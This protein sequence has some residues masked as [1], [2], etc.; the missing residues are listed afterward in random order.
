MRPNLAEMTG[1]DE[2]WSIAGAT[3][4][5]GISTATDPVLKKFCTEKAIRAFENA[6]SI[7]PANIAHKVNLAL[8]YA[9]NPPPEE[10]MKG[11]LLLLELDK[12]NPGEPAVLLA[13]ARLALKTGQYDKALARL[14]SVLK[15]EPENNR[16]ICLLP[17][18]YNGLGNTAEAETV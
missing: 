5:G 8:C 18:A 17:E 9:E 7:N 10:P 6:Y 12:Q 3:F 16:A 1:S 2:R 13:L 4:F 14:Q 11:P 15:V